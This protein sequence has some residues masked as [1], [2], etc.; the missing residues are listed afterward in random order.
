MLLIIQ[1]QPGG[2]LNLPY[3]KDWAADLRAALLPGNPTEKR[4]ASAS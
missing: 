2:S 1:A 4:D 3:I